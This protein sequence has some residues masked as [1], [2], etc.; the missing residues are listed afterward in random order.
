[1]PSAVSVYQT[2]KTNPIFVIE[3]IFAIG[4]MVYGLYILGPLY[5]VSYSTA[6]GRFFE[7]P[8]VRIGMGFLY[9]VSGVVVLFAKIKNHTRLRT[10]GAFL[11]FMAF[12]FTFV[13]RVVTIG[14]IPLIWMHY[15]MLALACAVIYLHLRTYH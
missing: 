12:F 10:S 1:M 4:L 7:G 15:L 11:M 6:L 3:I 13:I 14:L 9:M 8:P 5:E 2:I